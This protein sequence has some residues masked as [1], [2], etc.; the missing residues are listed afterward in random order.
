[1]SKCKTLEKGLIMSSQDSFFAD[2]WLSPQLVA[3]LRRFN[4]WWEGAPMPLQPQT[5]RHLVA[6]IR[7]RLDA[8]IAPIIVVRGPRQVG[9]TTAGVSF[10]SLRIC[11]T[12]ACPPQVSCGFS[13]MNWHRCKG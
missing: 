12:K 3:D 11:S 8:E 10:K 1:M 9:K 13:L 4:P 5:R 2:S 6:Q 7:R